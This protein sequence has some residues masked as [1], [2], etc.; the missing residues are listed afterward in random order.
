VRKRGVVP[1]ILP[2]VAA[3]VLNTAAAQELSPTRYTERLRDLLSARQF[4]AEVCLRDVNGNGTEDL[5]VVHRTGV[6][7]YPV[8]APPPGM[9]VTEFQQ[10][11]V[12]EAFKLVTL[13]AVVQLRRD[14]LAPQR[15]HV[16]LRVFDQLSE[17][18]DSVIA[19]C[20]GTLQDRDYRLC[21]V[22][23]TRSRERTDAFPTLPSC[24]G[25]ES[26]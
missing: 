7:P 22:L 13:D 15:E 21:L 1:S 26:P 3:G 6:G 23:A 20:R 25:P 9:D 14:S 5:L 16:Y 10:G 8:P 17:V 12:R 11:I 2:M 18:P 24:P 19:S 4:G